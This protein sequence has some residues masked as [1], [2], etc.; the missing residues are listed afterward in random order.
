MPVLTLDQLIQDDALREMANRLIAAGPGMVFGTGQTQS[1]KV[2]MLAALAHAMAGTR[3]VTFLTDRERGFRPFYPLPDG[4]QEVVVEATEEAWKEVV[5]S[6]AVASAAV[7]LVAPLDIVNGRAVLAMSADRWVL[8]AVN[9][10]LIG[11]DAAYALH[12]I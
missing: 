12:E 8:G 4:W 2:T 9:T 7:V 1:G 6:P 11:L 3:P 10:A 5:N